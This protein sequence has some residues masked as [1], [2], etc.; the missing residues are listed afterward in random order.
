MRCPAIG[1]GGSFEVDVP[2]VHRSGRGDDFAGL[3]V[4]D[5]IIVVDDTDHIESVVNG[6]GDDGAVAVSGDVAGRVELG[7]GLFFRGETEVVGVHGLRSREG[8]ELGVRKASGVVGEAGDGAV[9]SV[10]GSSAGIK[11]TQIQSVD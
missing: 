8:L 11:E 3:G 1:Q 6:C 10:C 9:E 2:A 4:V 5:G 7:Q